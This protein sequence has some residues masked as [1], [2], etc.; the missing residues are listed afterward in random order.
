M[1]GRTMNARVLLV[2]F[3]LVVREGLRAILA[4]R[5]NIQVVGDA[6]TEEDLLAKLDETSPN[7]VLTEM[8]GRALD[9]VKVIQAARQQDP[10][11]CVIV[12]SVLPTDAY[13]LDAVRAGAQGYLLLDDIT[14][15]DLL[16]NTIAA[17]QQG[18]TLVATK[19]LRQV[20][21]SQRRSA[22]HAM[23][24]GE[25]GSRL[26]RTELQVLRLLAEGHTNKEIGATLMIKA[27][28]AK[29]H[30]KAVVQKLGARSRTQAAVLAIQRG[31]ANPGGPQELGGEQ[32][33]PPLGVFAP[34][35]AN[36]AS[37]ETA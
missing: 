11:R 22:N 3:N 31:L 19:L 35:R 37:R 27:E 34:S 26:T 33:G 9:G 28:T 24:L 29:R 13:I 8:R 12:I 17:A 16:V 30:V 36:F 20:A 18:G 15:S 2:D 21:D 7:V 6:L 4:G 1:W 25:R 10:E 5:K 14:S 32:Q 23:G